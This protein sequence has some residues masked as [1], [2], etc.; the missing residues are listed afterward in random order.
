MFKCIVTVRLA[1]DR[2][3]NTVSRSCFIVEWCHRC[4]EDAYFVPLP[5]NVPSAN[6]PQYIHIHTKI[7]TDSNYE[8]SLIRTFIM[9]RIPSSSECE[10]ARQ[11]SLP[12]G[13]KRC[14]RKRKQKKE[15]ELL[16]TPFVLCQCYFIS[17]RSQSFS[18]EILKFKFIS[19]WVANVYILRQTY[20][21]DFRA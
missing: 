5:S 10:V 11:K 9:K 7:H 6:M 3:E 13:K 17:L 14:Q 2:V 21:C 20:V 15:T 16:L 4:G 8:I 18:T 12:G 19:D 1:S